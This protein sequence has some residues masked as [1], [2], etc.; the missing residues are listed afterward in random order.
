MTQGEFALWPVVGER[1]E[2][3]ARAAA[4]VPAPAAAVFVV[5]VRVLAH[6][7]DPP[8]SMADHVLEALART[9]SASAVHPLRIRVVPGMRLV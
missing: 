3:C 1:S 7:L 8:G 5:M 9:A 4:A 6:A 2:A